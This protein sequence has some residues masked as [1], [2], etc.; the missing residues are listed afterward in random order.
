M[1]RTE[2][3]RGTEDGAR[4]TDIRKTGGGRI[5]MGKADVRKTGGRR[6]DMRKADVRK[7]GGR[8]GSGMEN[9]ETE[10][11]RKES[12]GAENSGMQSSGI[13][14]GGKAVDLVIFAGQSNMSG[15]GSAAEATACEPEAGFEYKSVGSP[16][17]LVP[18]I[19]PF[20]LGEDKPGGIDDRDGRGGTKRRGSMVSGFVRAY[21][22]RTGR[23][24]VAV[25]ASVGGT[26]TAEWKER[27]I[28]DAVSRLDSARVFLKERGI[29]PG[30]IFVVWCQGETDGDKGVSAREYMEN[31]R[32][33][34]ETFQRHGAEKCFLIQIGHFNYI[35]FP[36]QGREIDRRYGV[37][38]DAQKTL[39]ESDG[40]FIFAGSFQGQLENMADAYHYK[41]A[42]YNAVGKEAGGVMAEYVLSSLAEKGEE[43]V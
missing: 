29:R 22:G 27:Y 16:E 12:G 18:I 11:R 26:S 17:A 3:G 39:C 8:K 30:H 14:S 31:T 15:R 19:E 7:I 41:Q 33:L 13:G 1:G 36:D 25:S 35:D 9:R 21:Y 2:D 5:G 10:N 32:E 6:I 23:Q 34:F 4:K 42:A 28:G 38:R 37:I 43:S 40:D 24:I 20:G